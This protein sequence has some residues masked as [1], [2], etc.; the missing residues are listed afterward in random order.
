MLELPFRARTRT[1]SRLD[2]LRG[3]KVGDAASVFYF[4]APRRACC[5][6]GFWSEMEKSKGTCT[7]STPRGKR[8]KPGKQEALQEG[9]Q[10]TLQEELQQVQQVQQVKQEQAEQLGCTQH[11]APAQA[12]PTPL[13]TPQAAG[14]FGPH[15]RVA[16][17]KAPDFRE[18]DSGTNGFLT[19][20]LGA[21]MLVLTQIYANHKLVV[22]R[23]N[24]F[25]AVE[26]P[27]NRKK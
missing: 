23:L 11:T 4:M 21:R 12:A 15:K 14:L 3:R 5:L 25:M 19:A 22:T 6:N 1:K 7:R 9:M 10:L 24:G 8:R 26:S 18:A 27:E 16:N 13:C 2:A 17:Q 20:I